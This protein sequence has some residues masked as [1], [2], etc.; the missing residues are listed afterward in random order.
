MQLLLSLAWRN[1][2]SRPARSILTLVA[3]ALGVGMILGTNLAAATSRQQLERTGAILAGGADAEVFAFAEQG[4][5]EEMVK[6]IS[7]LP[8]VR[9]AAPLVSKRLN[10]QLRGQPVTFQML[11]LDLAAERTLHPL[12]VVAGSQLDPADGG[13]V[14]VERQ[15]AAAHQVGVGSTLVLFT[16]LGPD[17][18]KVRGVVREGAF[19]EN[20]YGAVVYVPLATAQHAFRLGA[21]VSQ[22]SVK[23]RP[24]SQYTALRADLRSAAIEEYTIRDNHAFLATRRDP[25]SD[26][27]PV[28][29]FFS[30]LTLLIGLFL[31]YNNLAVTVSERR[32]EI[33]LL[34]AAGA[35]PGWVRSLFLG[36]ALIL[37][38]AGS[39]LGMG[40]GIFVASGLVAYVRVST[41]QADLQPVLSPNLVVAVFVLGVV[42]TMVCAV[43]P[44]QRAS[45][46]APLEAIR[47]RT[48]Y[49]AETRR[50]GVAVAGLVI[51]VLAA[52]LLAMII[53]S[54]DGGA[55]TGTRLALVGVAVVLIFV[56]LLGVAPV[57][58]GPLTALF[59]LP[60]G[61]LFPG[62]AILARNDIIRRPN[63]S[64]L[65]I[66]GLLVSSALV[67][68]VAG[69][70][71]GS[72]GAGDRWVDSLF[73]SDKIMVSPVH[74]GDAIRQEITALPGVA[75]TSPVSFF[76]LRESDPTGRTGDRAL[77]MAAIDALDYAARGR[78][79]FEA[80]SRQ[81]AFTQLEETRAIFISSRLARNR[82]LRVGSRVLLAAAGDQKSYL[83]AAVLSHT[84]PSPGGDETALLSRANAAQDFGVEGFNLLQVLPTAVGATPDADLRDVALR[85]GM[86]FESV[87]DI[88]SGVRHGI[89][90]L[91]FMLTG[92]ALVG[93]VLGLM[94]V[95]T[96]ILLNINES[97]REFGLLR[98]VGLT[99]GQ[100]G[101]IILT[102][103]SLLGLSGALTGS[104]VGLLLVLVMVRG[105]ASPG[106]RPV[107]IAPWGVMLAVL[108]V[109]LVGSL[110]AV[111]L[112]ARRV[113]SRSVVDALRFE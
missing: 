89:D 32:R 77:S 107:Y 105:A 62:E 19:A 61:L 74:Q 9:L 75:A 40:I 94:S 47:P 110:L 34:R 60:F 70:T 90:A 2:V 27:Q 39:L 97:S 53:G 54:N 33:G 88:R 109:T 55:L 99:T 43:L 83:V 7:T 104:G 80:G 108:A 25:F 48:L 31:I 4:F 8:E 30:L 11:G 17:L 66:A 64:T 113:A 37:G 52:A 45:R 106:F 10:G 100:L 58:I 20:G 85:Y 13:G 102:Q 71:Q 18:F 87:A 49:G 68:S 57:L 51:L 22:V 24:E 112:P 101:R 63:R 36:Q 21:R 96:T 59:A 56:G 86:Q 26:V 6:V 23:L 3:V 14:L 91:L 42:A 69:L 95:V 92:T 50:A 81:A 67:V 82:D 5:G 35:T 16:S 76:A 78:L 15:W 98:A 1:S 46:L 103:A 72:L 12:T 41:G 65:T 38:S 29:I 84:L 28:L 73:V 44:A 111:L 79:D 93:I